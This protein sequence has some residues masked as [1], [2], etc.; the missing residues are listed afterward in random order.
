MLGINVLVGLLVLSTS[1]CGFETVS[2][3]ATGTCVED[4][5]EL[6]ALFS[7]DT[8]YGENKMTVVAT[9]SPKS[10][11]PPGFNSATDYKNT[12]LDSVLYNLVKKGVPSTPIETI[13]APANQPT[14]QAIFEN[15]NYLVDYQIK[16]LYNQKSPD[17]NKQY[18]AKTHDF[19]TCYGEPT[20]VK[21]LNTNMGNNGRLEIK[22]DRPDT[23]NAPNVCYYEV[24]IADSNSNEKKKYETDQLSFVDP[25]SYPKYSKSITVLAINSNKF[26]GR[27]CYP[28]FKTDNCKNRGSGGTTIKW[29]YVAPT[30]PPTTTKKN[31]ASALRYLNPLSAVIGLFSV[32]FFI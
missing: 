13:V 14:Q 22:W 15:L 2:V 8:A 26:N 23:V 29:D 4:S 7:P 17:S 11:L 6:N 10:P 24:I 27:L 21:N 5:F 28:Q 25:D 3:R 1:P 32:M 20:K 18:D 12:C 9:I 19:T 16:I 30:N 31:N